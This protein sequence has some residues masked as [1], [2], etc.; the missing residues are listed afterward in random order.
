MFDLGGH[1]TTRS[2]W[3]GCFMTVDGVVYVVDT[4]DHQRFS[5]ARAELNNAA[6]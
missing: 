4:T 2:L 3:K 5:E 6:A 1:E